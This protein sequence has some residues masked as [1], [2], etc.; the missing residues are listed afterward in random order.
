MKT[1]FFLVFLSFLITGTDI[2]A[3]KA[4]QELQMVTYNIGLGILT[5]TAGAIINK[6]KEQSVWD[7]V[8]KTWWQ[9]AAGGALQYTGKKMIYQIP[10]NENYWWGLPSKFVHSAGTSICHNAAMGRPFGSYWVL[11]YGPVRTN[12]FIDNRHLRV[13]PQLNLLFA[14]DLYNGLQCGPI[15]WGVTLKTGTFA[16]VAN[17][18]GFD[19]N[20]GW[21]KYSGIAFTRSF[22]YADKI[23]LKSK[24][25]TFAH[26]IIHTYQSDEYTVINLYFDPLKNKIKNK[27]VN[28]LFKYI[29]VEVPFYRAAYLLCYDREQ[30]HFKNFFEFEAQFFSTNQYVQRKRE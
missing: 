18:I 10:R 26:E 15:D 8:K 20:E 27:T 13:Q 22:V 17:T 23:P 2:N 9:G 24:Y 16:F 14:Y 12:F 1:K 5:T 29:Y 19:S 3:Q 21:S 6:P 11:D 25:Q 7:C 28:T 30:N 4:G